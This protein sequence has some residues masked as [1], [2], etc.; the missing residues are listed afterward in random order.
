MPSSATAKTFAGWLLLLDWVSRHEVYDRYK[1]GTAAKRAL[2]KQVRSLMT[3]ADLL[4]GTAGPVKLLP[5][6]VVPTPDK[7]RERRLR[8]LTLHSL[9]RYR[10]VIK[11]RKHADTMTQLK[12]THF[13]AVKK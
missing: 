7:Q 5:G 3:P 8:Q 11:R 6:A 4:E 10:L 1:M 9:F 12:I 13:F 2:I